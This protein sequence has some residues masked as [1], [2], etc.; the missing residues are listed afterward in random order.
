[1]EVNLPRGVPLGVEAP[2]VDPDGDKFVKSDRE[3]ARL[4]VELFKP[5]IDSTVVVFQQQWQARK[6]ADIW[7]ALSGWLIILRIGSLI[8]PS[9]SNTILHLPF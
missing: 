3:L 5:I 8:Q 7:Y 9:P 2:N 4:V 6:A 1:M